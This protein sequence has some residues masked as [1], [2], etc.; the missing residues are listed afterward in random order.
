V[1][2]NLRGGQGPEYLAN[3]GSTEAGNA[4]SNEPMAA[5]ARESESAS[6]KKERGKKGC[7][8]P[9]LSKGGQS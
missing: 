6:E 2:R 9:P 1:E 4:G 3:S 5:I 7:D 8:I